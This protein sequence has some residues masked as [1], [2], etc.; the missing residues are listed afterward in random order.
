MKGTARGYF[1]REAAGFAGRL[2]FRADFAAGLAGFATDLAAFAGFA[3]TAGLAGLAAFSGFRVRSRLRRG[4]RAGR[5]RVVEH[6]H[7]IEAVDSR[8]IGPDFADVRVVG[9]AQPPRR[10]I[11]GHRDVEMERHAGF[12]EVHPLRHRLEV[13]DRFAALDLDEPGQFLAAGQHEI[14]KQGQGANLDRSDLL[15]ADIDGHVELPLVFRLEV[16]N[17]AIVFELFAN[18]PDKDG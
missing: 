8:P 13:V 1:L 11:D 3:A 15:I 17:Q 18:G 6:P 4:T 7:E 14:G 5:R 16:P 10:V 2:A 9:F 12:G